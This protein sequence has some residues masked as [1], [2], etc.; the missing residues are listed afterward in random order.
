MMM[1][2]RVVPIRID[3][4]DIKTPWIIRNIVLSINVFQNQRHTFQ[5]KYYSTI[6]LENIDFQKKQMDETKWYVDLLDRTSFK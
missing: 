4:K 1:S 6:Y 3:N 5:Y 2:R